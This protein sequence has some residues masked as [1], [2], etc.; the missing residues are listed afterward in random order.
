MNTT[1]ES[2]ITRPRLFSRVKNERF[3]NLTDK[4]TRTETIT[5]IIVVLSIVH[6]LTGKI[7]FRI[8]MTDTR[9][10]KADPIDMLMAGPR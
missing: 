9:M 10:L 6:I 3:K 2:I 4:N 5:I 1:V 8:K 7:F